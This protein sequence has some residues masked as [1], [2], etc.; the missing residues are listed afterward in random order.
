MPTG[1]NDASHC[2]CREGLLRQFGPRNPWEDIIILY[3]TNP[4]VLVSLP[5]LLLLENVVSPAFGLPGSLD[6]LIMAAASANQASPIV[7][8]IGGSIGSALALL[9]FYPLERARIE[10]QA[11]ASHQLPSRVK[12]Q[13]SHANEEKL[14][15]SVQVQMDLEKASPSL[16]GHG[17]D[18][19]SPSSSWSPVQQDSLRNSE[20][21]SRED[22]NNVGTSDETHPSWDM[23]SSS[24]EGSAAVATMPRP[25]KSSLVKCLAQLNARGALYQGVTPVITTIFASQFVF[26]FLNAYVQRLMDE[27]PMFRGGKGSSSKAVLSLLSSCLAGIGNVL[28]T[29]PLWVA[30]MTI[31]TGEA[32]SNSLFKELISIFR[33]KGL[34]HLW[35]GTSASI[36]LVSNPVIQFFSYEQLKHARL[37]HMHNRNKTPRVESSVL[38]PAEAFLVGAMAKAIATVLTYPL[39]LTQTVLR[40]ENNAYKGIIDCL[41]QLYRRAGYREWYTGMRAK[42]LQSV[43]TAAFTF[44]TYE[45][46]LGAVQMAL[47]R[48]SGIPQASP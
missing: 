29:N 34:K 30:N 5:Y 42:L 26:F 41:V 28:M 35:S 27:L 22:S 44:L 10:L 15:D 45:Q 31:V 37:A 19:V 13:D 36:F 33:S 7:H 43:L 24:S 1:S 48:S 21:P 20:V 12:S 6:P 25:T 2:G 40:L 39:Q 4:K 14:L 8:A 16:V 3:E 11:Q 47:I 38:P 23:E 9:L 18:A 46:I 17:A 32:K